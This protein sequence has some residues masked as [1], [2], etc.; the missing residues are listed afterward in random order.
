M[1]R[2]IANLYRDKYFLSAN[3]FL[4]FVYVLMLIFNNNIF[5]DKLFKSETTVGDYGS[6]SY[7]SK[8]TC[9]VSKTSFEMCAG[10]MS[11]ECAAGDTSKCFSDDPAVKESVK[12]LNKETL[13]LVQKFVELANCNDPDAVSSNFNKVFKPGI[14]NAITD[15]KSKN[16]NNDTALILALLHSIKAA[17]PGNNPLQSS[18]LLKISVV[19][20]HNA[21]LTYPDS[22]AAKTFKGRLSDKLDKIIN[23]EAFKECT[24]SKN[25]LKKSVVDTIMKIYNQMKN[26]GKPE[27][28]LK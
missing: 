22:T 4:V 9:D 13:A 21:L 7:G 11:T 5:I 12:K 10:N 14:A 18:N 25:P 17:D 15:A 1:K 20:L 2:T 28:D 26:I 6:F 16:L 23:T 24:A 27:F 19:Y 8:D 3:I